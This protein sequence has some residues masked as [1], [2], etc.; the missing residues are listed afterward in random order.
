MLEVIAIQFTQDQ[1]RALTGVS[2]E[3]LRHWR[4]VIPYLSSK[5]GKAARFTF[6][7]LLGLAVSYEL[8]NSF[9]INI[10][11]LSVGIDSLFR[12]LE[13]SGIV[14]LD[15]AAVFVTAT[16][17]T[18]FETGDAGISQS[19]TKPTL[20]IPLG[21]LMA[22]IQLHMLPTMPT[23]TQRVLPFPPEAVQSRS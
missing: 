16:E 17:A 4:K 3:T 9:G 14:K 18:L 23:S 20:V 8:V 15:D 12:L 1:T 2:V 19:L 10:T 22:R 11:G 6:A 13:T 7:D 5:S 21:P